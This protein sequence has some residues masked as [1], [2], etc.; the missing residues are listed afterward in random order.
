M[1]VLQN[2]GNLSEASLSFEQSVKFNKSKKSVTK[3][4]Y[5]IARIKI[6]QRDFY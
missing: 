2:K 1:F 5:E 4:L 6:E 3:S